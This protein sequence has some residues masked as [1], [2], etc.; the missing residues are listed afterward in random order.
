MNIKLTHIICVLVLAGNFLISCNKHGTTTNTPSTDTITLRVFKVNEGFGFDILVNN[1]VV[2]NQTQIPVIEGIKAFKTVNDASKTGDFM[3]QKMQKG[4]FPPTVN[5][6]DLD[7][8]GV[9]Y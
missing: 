3:I 9:S 1:K 6:G 2:I 8:L 4:Y 5:I 7:S